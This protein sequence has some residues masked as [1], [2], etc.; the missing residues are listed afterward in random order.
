MILASLIGGLSS[1]VDKVSLSRTAWVKYVDSINS[2][3][4]TY[5]GAISI[6]HIQMTHDTIDIECRYDEGLIPMQQYGEIYLR[7]K[8]VMNKLFFMNMSDILIDKNHSVAGLIAIN[9]SLKVTCIGKQTNHSFVAYLSPTEFKDIANLHLDEFQ[10]NELRL[11]YRLMESNYRCPYDIE[12]GMKMVSVYVDANYVTF[13]IELDESIYSI[14]TLKCLPV[15]SMKET[16]RNELNEE[17]GIQLYSE[18]LP[19]KNCGYGLKYLYVGSKSGKTCSFSLEA[20]ELPSAE[21]MR[22]K[23]E[24]YLTNY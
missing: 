23:L 9:A 2:V 10:R 15:S 7:N 21:E 6:N 18:L 5:Q 20:S 19:A 16:L 12:K 11:K 3:C 1:C 22:S 4:P 8:D 14:E 13:K 17:A 24:E